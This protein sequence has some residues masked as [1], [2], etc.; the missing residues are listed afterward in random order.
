M[1]RRMLSEL[2]RV[3]ARFHNRRHRRAVYRLFAK[4]RLPLTVA[5]LAQARWY[6]ADHREREER[7]E[8]YRRLQDAYDRAYGCFLDGT[9]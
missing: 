1:S 9:R 6:A 3:P 5:D 2:F 8:E 4:A 7:A